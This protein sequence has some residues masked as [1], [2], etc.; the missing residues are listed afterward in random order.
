M[1]AKTGPEPGL[2]Q[3]PE[4]GPGPVAVPVAARALGI[5]ERAVRK[6]I[7][8]GTLHGE[9]FGRSFRVWLPADAPEPGPG[10][11]PLRGPEPGRGP[12]PI[13]ATFRVTPAEIERAVSRTSAQYMGDLRTMLAEV[14][15]VYEGQLAAKDRTIGTQA[16]TLALQAETIA[17]LRHRAESAESALALGAHEAAAAPSSAAPTDDWIAA[18]VAWE[19]DFQAET[20]VRRSGSML[21]RSLEARAK[22]LQEASLKPP[23]PPPTFWSRLRARLRGE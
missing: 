9:P 16:D 1:S 12:E 15:K 17:A 3:V 7:A 4:Q 2:E 21:P 13:E 20:G 11:G 14:G 5:S 22:W 23:P 8:A 18:A 10:P 19:R 6:R